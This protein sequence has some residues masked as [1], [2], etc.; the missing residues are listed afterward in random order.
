MKKLVKQM[1][2]AKRKID[3]LINEKPSNP[4]RKTKK[5]NRF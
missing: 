3:R 1:I 4:V 5:E 2:K